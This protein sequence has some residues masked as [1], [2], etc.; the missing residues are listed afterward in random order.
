MITFLSLKKPR[1][2][3]A[4]K[5]QNGARLDGMNQAENHNVG[6]KSGAIGEFKITKFSDA[7]D[8]SEAVVQ[9]DFKK[10]QNR[11]GPSSA[12]LAP[13]FN[14]FQGLFGVKNDAILRLAEL[15]GRHGGS[16]GVFALNDVSEAVKLQKLLNDRDAARGALPKGAKF[17]DYPPDVKLLIETADKALVPT[18]RLLNKTRRESTES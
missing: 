2:S 7:N 18:E 11:T 12:D 10:V 17:P 9:F 13:G 16:Q 4:P 6:E 3:F 8:F 5:P 14:K 15:F 1:D